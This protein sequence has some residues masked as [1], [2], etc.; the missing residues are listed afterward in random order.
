MTAAVSC[1]S[2]N[3]GFENHIKTCPCR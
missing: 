3:T 1:D 2:D